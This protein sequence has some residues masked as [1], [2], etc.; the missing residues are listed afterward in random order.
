MTDKI[1]KVLDLKKSKTWKLYQN[2]VL[3]GTFDRLHNG[4]KIL[5]TEALLSCSKKITV[6]VTNEA[7]TKGI[8]QNILLS[9]KYYIFFFSIKLV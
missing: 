1:G 6:G 7:M 4:H 3:G 5:L 9:Q 8:F 2:V